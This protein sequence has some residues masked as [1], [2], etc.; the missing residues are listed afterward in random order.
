[1]ERRGGEFE[2]HN[3]LQVA[4]WK[5]EEMYKKCGGSLWEKNIVVQKW[6]WVGHVS[7]RETRAPLLDILELVDGKRVNRGRPKGNWLS[8]FENFLG[9]DWRIYS[10][11]KDEWN[12]WLDIWLQ[13]LWQQNI[14]PWH[15][16]PTT[17]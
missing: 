6:K 3:W 10:F 2:Y 17:R 5:A 1:M 9:P 8:L 4:T 11:D 13:N 14:I 16:S 7:R 15:E 12:S